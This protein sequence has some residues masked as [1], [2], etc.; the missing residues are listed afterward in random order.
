VISLPNQQ[1]AGP[2]GRVTARTPGTSNDLSSG[3]V[4]VAV[5]MAAGVSAVTG[6]MFFRGKSW[7]RRTPKLDR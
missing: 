6:W 7:A 1:A 5:V 2:T 3:V 4:T